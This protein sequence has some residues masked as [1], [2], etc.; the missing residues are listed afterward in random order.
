MLANFGK[1][2]ERS[3]YFMEV[4]RTG[5]STIERTLRHYFPKAKAT[6]AKH[7]P[8]LPPIDFEAQAESIISVRNPFSRA[9]SCWQY[10]TKPGAYTFESWLKERLDEGFFDTFIEARPQVFWYG[11]QEK[12]NHVLQQETL[13]AD[14]HALIQELCENP[15]ISPLQRYN[16][17]NGQWVNRVKA[18]T[19]RPK[20][21]EE[22][23]EGPEKDMV[24]ELYASDFASFEH[25]YEKDIPEYEL[26]AFGN[27]YSS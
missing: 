5:T 23:Y 2:P 6:Y 12:W 1:Y 15:S 25:L 10:F 4:P 9:V 20:P 13:E 22:Y 18:R 21:W 17:I 11:L 16:D 27:T 26:K 7:W 3:W 14:F 8:L 24:L 19:S